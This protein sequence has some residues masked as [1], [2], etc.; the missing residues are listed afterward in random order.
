MVKK[1]F[2]CQQISDLKGVCEAI[3]EY[4]ENGDVVLLKGDL[5]SGKTTLTKYL[6]KHFFDGDEGSS[7]TFSL[8]NMYTGT[9]AGHKIDIIHA[10]LYRLNTRDEVFDIGL[11]DQIALPNTLAF[12][13]W[14]ELAEGDL[15]PNMTLEFSIMP[16]GD[17]KIVL[18]LV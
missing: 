8:I 5:G 18:S 3:L 15:D 14:P 6:L 17:R 9:W 1:T 13:E 7:P 10:D 12:I 2:I 11:F 4:L 16:N